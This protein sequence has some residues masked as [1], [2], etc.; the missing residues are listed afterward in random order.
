MYNMYNIILEFIISHIF[1]FSLLN[2]S[3]WEANNFRP[4]SNKTYEFERQ[5]SAKGKSIFSKFLQ[6][7]IVF[8]IS[9]QN[10]SGTQ[11]LRFSFQC[12]NTFAI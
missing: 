4:P 12:Y 2:K 5:F 1:S 7:L 11:T 3:Y 9:T 8:P 10:C 6:R